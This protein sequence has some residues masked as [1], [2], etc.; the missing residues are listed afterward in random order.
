MKTSKLLVVGSAL[1]VL[2]L[3]GLAWAE[4]V[5]PMDPVDDASAPAE[6]MPA[7]EPSAEEA[8]GVVEEASPVAG[9]EVA[10]APSPA[11]MAE[12][13]AAPM[14]PAEVAPTAMEP[15]AGEVAPTAMEPTAGEV[16]P[17]AM[18]PTA[19]TAMEPA[20][21][22][23]S[24]PGVEPATE[25]MAASGSPAE[26]PPPAEAL[27]LP[28]LGM[29]G[30]DSEGRPGRIHVVV[31][32]DTLWDIS[33]AYLGTPWVW[34]SI[35]QDNRDI[36]N[37][38]LIFPGDHIWITPYEMRKITPEEAAA[39]LAGSPAE[40]EPEI[41]AAPEPEPVVTPAPVPVRQEQ[42]TVRISN[43]EKVGLVTEDDIEAA[44]SIVSAVVK[45]VMLSQQDRVWIGLGEDDVEVGDEFTIFRVQEKVYDPETGRMLG[46]HVN[47]LG[48]LEVLEVDAETSLAEIRESAVDIVVGDR[49][50]VRQ[51]PVEEIAVQKS[52][53]GD[54]RG[55]I[56]FFAQQRTLMGTMEYAYLNRGTLDGLEV[57]SPLQVYRDAYKARETTRGEKVQVPERVV[58][59][60]LVVKAEPEVA[61]ALIRH[62]EE[63]L[64]LGDRFRGSE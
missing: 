56:S 16:A 34:P 42:P 63:E 33:D 8:A 35:W 40:A 44:A 45:R 38:H 10:P 25:A 14:A 20:A 26:P 36:A 21:P 5:A 59:D 3:G 17:T 47:M 60:L 9:T 7:E 55:Q 64:A 32:G 30:Y 61:V 31:P 6:A 23:A 22:A 28:A 41:V 18:E 58:A 54:V 51:K 37:P 24:D 52:P 46:Y 62:T 48:W 4:D 27:V 39:L 49:L 11:A 43:R 2:A 15:T 53:G 57:G 12:P 13:D 19:G 1:I 29:L 50:M